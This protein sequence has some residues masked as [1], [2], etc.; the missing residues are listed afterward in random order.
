[1][2]KYKQQPTT[3]KEEKIYPSDFGSHASMVNE[4]LTEKLNDEKLVVCVDKEGPYVTAKKRLDD[5]LADP[6]R[7]SN[8]LAR[9][10]RQWK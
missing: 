2:A 8:R 1:M 3:K 6:N 7:Y 9:N 5:G 10:P 4:N